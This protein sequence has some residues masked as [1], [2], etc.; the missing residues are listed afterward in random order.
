MKLKSILFTNN[1]IW[2]VCELFDIVVVVV[3]VVYAD[4]NDVGYFTSSDLLYF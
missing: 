2:F 3:V 4:V 1:Y